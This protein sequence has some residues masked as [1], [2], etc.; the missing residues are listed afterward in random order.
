MMY[1]IYI[2]VIDRTKLPK[3][4]LFVDKKRREYHYFYI[5]DV[6]YLLIIFSNK[7]VELNTA[8]EYIKSN[9]KKIC[10]SFFVFFHFK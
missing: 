1:C 8:T 10:T 7:V 9:F 6:L 3:M 2:M 5:L 4:Y